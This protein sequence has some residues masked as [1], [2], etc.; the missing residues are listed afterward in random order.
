MPPTPECFVKY[1]DGSG[2]SVTRPAANAFKSTS[3]SSTV[4]RPG[5][6]IAEDNTLER[7]NTVPVSACLT[8]NA[9]VIFFSFTG[10]AGPPSAP[11]EV[12]PSVADMLCDELG[13]TNGEGTRSIR[14]QH[15]TALPIRYDM[16]APTQIQNAMHFRCCSHPKQLADLAQKLQVRPQLALVVQ[17]QLPLAVQH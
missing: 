17:W 9:L 8:S 15:D 4:C 14:W 12:A 7:E 13:G 5:G 10:D 1:F 6:S 3:P 16:V 11:L 2:R